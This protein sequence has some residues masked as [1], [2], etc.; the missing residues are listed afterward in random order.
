MERVQILTV[1]NDSAINLIQMNNGTL[2]TRAP[3]TR[4]LRIADQLNDA[5]YE[6]EQ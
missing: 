2:T 6:D 1:A 5:A 4:L 3:R